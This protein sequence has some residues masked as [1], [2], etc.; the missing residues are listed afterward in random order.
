MLEAYFIDVPADILP[1]L[2]G[3]VLVKYPLK[4]QKHSAFS[5]G[6]CFHRVLHPVTGADTD[7]IKGLVVQHASD[8]H[9]WRHEFRHQLLGGTTLLAHYPLLSC[10]L[11]GGHHYD[12]FHNP[13]ILVA[14]P[15]AKAGGV[16]LVCRRHGL[17][18]HNTL[19]HPS[20]RL[21][22]A[23]IH[24]DTFRITLVAV[25]FPVDAA[26]RQCFIRRVLGP[27]IDSLQHGAH[28]LVLEDFNP[29]E[30]PL[31]DRTSKKGAAKEN[32]E[33]YQRCSA[34][35]LS[36]AFRVL[37]PFKKEFTFYSCAN[38]SSSC[39][40]RALISQSLLSHVE[41]VS[42]IMPADP[43]SDITFAVKAAFRMITRVQLGPGLWRLPAYMVERPGV[44]RVIEA[45]ER[46]AV[47]CGDNFELLILRLNAGLRAYAKEERKRV[48]ATM[49][50]L[51][52]EV[53]ALKQSWMGDPGC[54][55][56]KGLLD[57]RESQLKGYQLVQQE[58]LHVMAGMKEEVLDEVASPFLST[59]IK[60]QKER[61]KISELDVGGRMVADN[62]EILGATSQY[63]MDLFGMV[64]RRTETAWLPAEGRRLSQASAEGVS[65]D[66][67]ENEVKRAFR[68][69]AKDKAPGK[70][71]LPREL[72]EMH[73]DVLGK[74][75]IKPVESFAASASLPTSTKDAVTILLHK[76]GGRDQL[77]NYRPITLLSF[78]Y[79][80]LARVVADR[81]KKVLH[82]VI[83]PE[84][85]GF[86]P[87]RRLSDAVGLVADIIEVAKN[88]DKDWYL[89][90]V[91][92]RKAFDSVSRGFLFT[93]LDRLGARPA[94][95]YTNKPINKRLDGRGG[96][97]GIGGA[98]GLPAGA[99]HFL[100]CGPAVGARSCKPEAGPHGGRSVFGVHG[101]CGRYNTAPASGGAYC[102]SGEAV[103]GL[104]SRLRLSY[105]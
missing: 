81:M 13:Q 75:F 41:F 15:T 7:K 51:Q 30:D 65:A 68:S 45:V 35:H 96:G 39:I 72:F 43:I 31:L 25:Y 98:S 74:H 58:R 2:V 28:L 11:C 71:G 84:Q 48:G 82:E 94:Q 26:E 91:D 50:H 85:Y 92:F 55:R 20:G 64:R 101:L 6:H 10:P 66:W 29:V 33:L 46:Q 59:K 70:D 54:A 37:H 21:I 79:K 67:T 77:E 69:M 23:D 61:T 19:I 53:A 87:G 38:Q 60:A 76:K 99:V 8:K 103:R 49:A 93:L 57:E 24:Y 27:V 102:R 89:L 100:V 5:E 63:Y 9:R 32:K 4:V 40:D 18:L 36:D 3:E 42:H 104:Q 88:K 14:S 97:S 22:A 52:R 62:K 47:A 17:S 80:V 1:E 105:K 56:L 78:T 34:F 73:W 12:K 95:G 86:L 44:R 90:L 83:S 16:A